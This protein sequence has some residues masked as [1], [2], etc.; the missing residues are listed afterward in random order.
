MTKPFSKRPM[1]SSMKKRKKISDDRGP[2]PITAQ[3]WDTIKSEDL[4]DP[5]A[6]QYL[7]A[8]EENI[9]AL[10]EHP[11]PIGD[12][13][14]SPVEGVVHRYPDRALLKITDTCTVYCRF[15]FRKE[16][17]GKGEG[18]LSINELDDALEYISAT[19]E[20]HEIILSGGDP[21]TLSNRRFKDLLKQLEE[22]KHIDIIRIHTRTPIV[23][24]KRI[25]ADFLEILNDCTK[26]LYLVLHVNHAQEINT[27]VESAFNKLSRTRAILLSQSVLLKGINDNVG[28][29][30]NLFRTLVNNRIK[31]YYLHHPDL[32]PGT[33]HFR[34]SIEKGQA[35]MKALRGKIS[36]L[37]I[38]TYVLDIP[39]GHGK[40]P[41]G[42]CSIHATEKDHYIVEDY[43]GIEHHYQD[44]RAQDD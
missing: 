26:A 27:A 2:L 13:A 24:P 8:A 38:P 39:G 34:V 16:M 25:D 17:V 29:L 22:I 10:N 3:V 41:I 11:D 40:A 12:N 35:L 28:S 19:P 14:H 15:C 43:Q 33:G 30:E 7:P 37:C 32:A 9:I 6:K 4:S 18:I 23:H 5:V 42:T 31:P 44:T 21:L 1:N 36:G 20:I